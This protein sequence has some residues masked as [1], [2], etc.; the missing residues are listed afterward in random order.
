MDGSAVGVTPPVR[1]M[2][3][4]LPISFVGTHIM[5]TVGRPVGAGQPPP[6]VPNTSILGGEGGVGTKGG[7]GKGAGGEWLGSTVG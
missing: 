5:G 1:P 6:F 4:S 2:P 3:P 7:G